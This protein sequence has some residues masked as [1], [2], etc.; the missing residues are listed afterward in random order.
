MGLD[1]SFPGVDQL[2]DLFQSQAFAV[3]AKGFHVTLAQIKEGEGRALAFVFKVHERAGELDE[4]FVERVQSGIPAFEP[5]VFKNVVCFVESAFVEG[6]EIAPV[7][8]I[9]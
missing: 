3:V 4:G 1:A 9:P 2:V 7:T 6:F 5:E 8:W